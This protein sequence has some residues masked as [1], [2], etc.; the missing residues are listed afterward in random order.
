MAVVSISKIQHR[1]GQK[2][3]G[4]GLPQ[5][6]SA[7][8]GWAIDTR[9]LYIGNGAVSEGAPA[10]G[11]TKILTEFDDLFSLAD[12]YAYKQDEGVLTG[13][14]AS[15]P[16]ERTL[17]ERLD[18]RVSVRAF[19]AVGD[20][21]ADDTESLQ[22]AINQ[23]YLGTN[24]H[25]PSSRV[26]LYI[27]AGTY[28][29][30]STLFVPPN[31]TLIGAGSNKSIIELDSAAN[32]PVVRTINDETDSNNPI[33]TN[34]T[35]LNQPRNIKLTG[36]SLIQS[37]VAEGILIES[38]RDSVFEDITIIGIWEATDTEFPDR[39]TAIKIDSL[40]GAVSSNNNIFKNCAIENFSYAVKSDWDVKYNLFEN[41]NFSNSGYGI[42]FGEDIDLDS[43]NPASGKI[44]GPSRNTVGNSQFSNISR[45]AI[46]IVQGRENVSQNN[47][48]REVG[49]QQA[50]DRSPVFPVLLFKT[51]SNVSENDYF[52]RTKNLIKNSPD[53][54]VNGVVPYV[55]EIEGAVSYKLS[56]EQEVDFGRISGA[57]IFRLPGFQ[58]Q[59]Y[60]L[61]YTITSESQNYIRSGVL[62]ITVLDV[63]PSAEFNRIELVDD[64][65][66]VG[67]DDFTDVIDFSAN[68]QDLGTFN[69]PNPGTDTIAVR[70]TV[71]GINVPNDFQAIMRFTIKAKKTNLD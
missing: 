26:Q 33:A 25:N 37:T 4:S 49:N 48:F 67:D 54:T 11:N 45:Y 16:V 44:Q 12:T 13:S 58:N 1:R 8:L 43:G 21:V 24:K 29:I 64:Y 7:E 60:E 63:P 19:G 28:R 14:N 57:T 23:L 65:S 42:V 5:L 10:V 51:Y 18:D 39:D 55:P 2:N 41:C 50:G 6:A 66:V 71:E 31:A 32:Q 20:G 59:T 40:S 53:F 27:E 38:C 70:A 9:E 46:Y 36:F 47:S 34:T 35:F 52:S 17:Q 22:R 61:D 3:V 56:Y 68:L 15:A 30:T 69:N 62:Q